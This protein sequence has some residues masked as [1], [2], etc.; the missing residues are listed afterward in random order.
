MRVR[1]TRPDK[2]GRGSCAGLRRGRALLTTTGVRDKMTLNRLIVE[3]E[4]VA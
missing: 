4:R 1:S 2:C 3:G